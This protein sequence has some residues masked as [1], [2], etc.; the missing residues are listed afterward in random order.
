L[1]IS[2]TT[3]LDALNMEDVDVPEIQNTRQKAKKKR[4]SRDKSKTASP[5]QS[6]FI[7]VYT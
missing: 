6:E 2:V 5:Q 3:Q 4:K 1:N 7:K